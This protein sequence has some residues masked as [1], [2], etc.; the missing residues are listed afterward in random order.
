MSTELVTNLVTA[1]RVYGI[2]LSGAL[3][4]LLAML[5]LWFLVLVRRRNDPD[6]TPASVFAFLMSLLV[7]A[8]F[9]GAVKY[10]C[11]W[12]LSPEFMAAEATRWIR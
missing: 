1:N 10:A 11:D 7:F 5:L 8:V 6:S 12:W 4:L 3:L 2:W 9:C